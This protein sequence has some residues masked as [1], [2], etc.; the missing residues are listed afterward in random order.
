LYQRSGDVFF[1]CAIYIAVNALLTMMIAQ[2]CDWQV[3]DFYS[4]LLETRNFICLSFG[5]SCIA[6]ERRQPLSLAK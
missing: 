3:G 6:I 1:G 2:V 4:I 5:E